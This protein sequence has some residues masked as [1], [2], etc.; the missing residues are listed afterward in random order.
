MDRT[1]DGLAVQDEFVIPEAM[2]V[3]GAEM[4]AETDDLTHEERAAY[5]WAAM[6]GVRRLIAE[7]ITEL[8]N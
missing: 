3:A 7:P 1:K 6:E 4:S 5:I 8:P 2:L